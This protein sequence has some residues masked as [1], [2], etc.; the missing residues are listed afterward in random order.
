MMLSTI[1]FYFFIA[2]A[3]ITAIAMLF[4]RNVF[5]AALMLIAVLLA[6]AGIYVLALAEMIAVTQI[7]VYAG[8]ILVVIIFGIMLTTRI[9]GKPLVVGNGN[10][11]P[12][13]L[14]GLSF[15]VIMVYLLAKENF[16]Q[17]SEMRPPTM[18]EFGIGLLSDY[19]LPFEIAGIILLVSLVGA[20]V[21]ASNAPSKKI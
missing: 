8:G 19:A 10:V 4:V 17:H 21:V 6:I 15:F 1:A 18:R 11:I 13:A 2:T 7:L 9:S 5:H 20:A 12:G 3:V 14:V 16:T